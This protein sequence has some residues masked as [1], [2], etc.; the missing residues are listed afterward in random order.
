MPQVTY[1]LTGITSDFSS[2][3]TMFRF[4]FY[5]QSNVQ[6]TVLDEESPIKSLNELKE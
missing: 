6:L 3:M 5:F 2:D 1:E 4:D